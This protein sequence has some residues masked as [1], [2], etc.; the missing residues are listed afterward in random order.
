MAP[1]AYRERACQTVLSYYSRS[2]ISF[3]LTVTIRA[4]AEFV[5]TNPGVNVTTIVSLCISGKPLCSLRVIQLIQCYTTPVHKYKMAENGTEPSVK[6]V[7][8][9]VARSLKYLV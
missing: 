3:L 2:P 5:L 8:A 6:R 1:K 7:K 4:L 9:G